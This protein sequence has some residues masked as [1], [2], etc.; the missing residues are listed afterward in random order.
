VELDLCPVDT[1]AARLR[2]LQEG[3]KMLTKITAR[4]LLTDSGQIEHPVVWVE[5]GK[6]ERI[7]CGNENDSTVTLTAGFFDVHVHGAVSQDFMTATVQGVAEVGR[8]LA[9]RGVAYYLPTTVTGPVEGTLRALETLAAAIEGPSVEEV[10]VPLG[11][12]LEGPFISHK[13]RGVQPDAFI[14]EPSVELFERQWEAS[15]GHIRLMTVA[16]ELPRALELIAHAVSKGVR[17]SLGHSNATAAEAL[18]GIAAG[19]TSATHMFN[20]MRAIDH[21]EPGIAGTVLD[22]HDLYAEAIC[23][24]VHVDPA[25]I[26]L[27]LKMKGEERAILI[28]DGISAT[29]MPEG[30]YMLGDLHV[31]VKDGVCL[32]GGVLAG[33]VLTMDRAVENLHEFT[34][35]AL[36]AAVRLASQNPA[37]MLGLEQ[38]TAI[39][40]GNDANFNV[41]NDAGARTGSILRG[42]AVA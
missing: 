28:T 23:D 10:A 26:R 29:G 40:P 16:P 9:T 17:V 19:A 25:M 27:W 36:G 33:S 37:R 15:R 31:E 6:I 41:Y 18:A 12:H 34:G 13:K 3:Q 2:P 35:V 11:V 24:G 1:A 21:R 39:Q 30:T 7:E 5:D 4:R 38:L 42:V 8:F 22:Y 32:S 14:E 20:A